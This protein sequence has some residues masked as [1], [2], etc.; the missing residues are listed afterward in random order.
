VSFVPLKEKI[1]VKRDADFTTPA[2]PGEISDKVKEMLAATYS[3]CI[4]KGCIGL[5][6]GCIDAYQQTRDD[7]IPQTCNVLLTWA[8]EG[9]RNVYNLTGRP[10]NGN[11]VTTGYIAMGFSEDKKM[12]QDSVVGCYLTSG[13][14]SV[15]RFYNPGYYNDKAP[16]K[17]IN[18]FKNK[19]FIVIIVNYRVII[20][21]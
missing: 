12:G 8:A 3:D 1:T 11:G 13:I 7:P 19:F 10:A 5:P 16:V 9:D 4:S 17:K 6:A 15:Q 20:T 14:P 2:P 18:F 21:D